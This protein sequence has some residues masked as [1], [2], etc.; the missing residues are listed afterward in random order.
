MHNLRKFTTSAN[1]LRVLV[2]VVYHK[3]Q[4]FLPWFWIKVPNIQVISEIIS[5]YFSVTPVGVYSE[6]RA[7]LLLS[8]I[9]ISVSASLS[10]MECFVILLH[11]QLFCWYEQLCFI[12]PF[13]IQWVNRSWMFSKQFL[14]I[15]VTLQ[16]LHIIFNI[17]I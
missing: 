1:N 5:S 9:R 6:P 12:P 14:P 8:H 10:I 4:V 2:I 11:Y 3:Y 16:V 7:Q 13:T 15:V 17:V